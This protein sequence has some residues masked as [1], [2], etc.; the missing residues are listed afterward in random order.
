LN[1]LVAGG[2]TGG[3]VYPALAVIEEL[4]RNYRN[5]RIGYVG[6]ARG[7]ESKV[8]RREPGV[9][10]FEV[11]AAGIERK[12]SF[13]KF[14]E[15]Q[16]NLTGL[17]QAAK[18]ITE[19]DPDLIIGTGGYVSFAPLFWGTVFGVPT[20]IH[21]Q[22]RAPGLVNRLLAP[23]VDAVLTSFPESEFPV[24]AKRVV[25]TGL[26]LRSSF[27][28]IRRQLQPQEAKLSLNLD[29]NKPLVLLAGGTH[30]A[31]MIHDQILSGAPEFEKKNVQLVVLAG[32]DAER[33]QLQI[34]Q[35]DQENIKVLGHTQNVGVWMRAADLM[36]CRAG[37]STLAEMMAIGVPS[38]VIPWSGAVQ[39]HQTHNAAWLEDG[40]A[41]RVMTESQ[42]TESNLTQ[43]ILE[44]LQDKVAL[45]QMTERQLELGKPDAT[46]HVVEEVSHHLQQRQHVP[47]YRHWR[48]WNERIGVAFARTGSFRQRFGL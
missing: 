5:I 44:L 33:L 34:D 3:H 17:C 42:C 48:R 40:K 10:F 13:K 9:E 12:L 21:E 45:S 14:T 39:G 19:F 41:C 25:Q 47:F 7:L 36:V 11:E 8:M 16:R 22:N 24:R 38:I 26:P 32:R 46:H 31:Q 23:R 37:G 30:G 18:V 27:K 1:I 20:L 43:E 4:R 15:I 6:T 28:A 29:P 2:G 35:Q